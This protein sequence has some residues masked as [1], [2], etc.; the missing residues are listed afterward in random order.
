MLLKMESK[1][2]F[3]PKLGSVASRQMIEKWFKRGHIKT[4]DVERY[5]RPGGN[6]S[7]HFNNPQ[8]RLTNR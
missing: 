3:R 5:G 6:T 8:N 1:N 4:D 7:K 2:P